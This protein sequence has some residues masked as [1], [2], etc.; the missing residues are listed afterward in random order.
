MASPARA[1]VL[2]CEDPVDVPS[3]LVLQDQ[4][5]RPSAATCA[6][7]P[8]D[9][10]PQEVLVAGDWH[11]D[12]T[13][14][15]AVLARLITLLP[16]ESP[17]I[18]LHAG[19][20]GVYADDDSQYF[21][22]VLNKSLERY[23]GILYFV[24]GNHEDFALLHQLA[25]THAPTTPVRVRPRIVWLPRGFR[26][27]WHGRTWLALG[28]AVSVDRVSRTPGVDWFPDEEITEAD[29][30]KVAAAGTADVMLCHDAPADV[31]L[32]LSAPPRWWHPDDLDRSAQHRQRLQAIVDIV[33]PTYLLHGHYHLSHYTVVE[34][35]HGPVTVT[36]LDKNNGRG[37][38]YRVLDVQVMGHPAR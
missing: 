6:D 20:L 19:D 31:P 14:S 32:R 9:Y 24:D 7:S 3:W 10:S 13:W 30:H 21:L 17:R 25:G 26:W 28:G 34:M 2:T 5:T 8:G 38:N 4:T 11:Q 12:P 18:V 35:N 22:D 33:R 29:T 37:V 1:W 23:D 36:G 15:R 27:T 16:S